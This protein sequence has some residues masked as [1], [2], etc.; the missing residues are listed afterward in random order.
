MT[1]AEVLLL[2]WKLGGRPARVEGFLVVTYLF[3]YLAS[4]ENDACG[5]LVNEPRLLERLLSRVPPA[6]GSMVIYAGDAVIEGTLELS[7]GLPMFPALL[8]SIKTF[9][10]TRSDWESVRFDFPV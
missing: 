2:D 4:N 8:H 5:V 9:T 6:A 7:T 3:A 1:V 10:F